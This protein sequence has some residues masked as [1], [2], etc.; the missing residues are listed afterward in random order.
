MLGIS[1]NSKLAINV[2]LHGKNY[3]QLVCVWRRA[4]GGLEVSLR[5]IN[6]SEKVW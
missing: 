1:Q 2:M 4:G 6:I 5:R 3:V